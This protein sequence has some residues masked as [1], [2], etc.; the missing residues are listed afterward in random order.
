[1][2]YTIVPRPFQIYKNVT[3]TI[4]LVQGQSSRLILTKTWNIDNL[5]IIFVIC[6]HWYQFMTL[7]FNSDQVQGQILKT[8]M[9]D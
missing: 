8:L 1:M 2:A 3:M 5:A 6:I 7:T 4:G 9:T